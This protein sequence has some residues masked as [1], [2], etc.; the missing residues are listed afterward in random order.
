[1]QSSD[2]GL[3]GH[4]NN[5]SSMESC[6]HGSLIVN[7]VQSPAS[8]SA[9]DES[10]VSIKLSYT[11]EP[12]QPRRTVS[13]EGSGPLRHPTP[14]LQSLQGAYIG[15]VERLEQ[16]AERLSLSS[17]IGE[18]L[19]KM[20]LEQRKSS[21]R[22]SSIMAAQAGQAGGILPSLRQVSTSSNMSNSIR[23]LNN[24]ARSGA[25]PSHGH[26]ISPAGSIRSTS[27]SIHLPRQRQKVLS[28]RVTRIS[29]LDQGE[30]PSRTTNFTSFDKNVNIDQQSIL[31]TE[32]EITQHPTAL[33]NSERLLQP[34][35]LQHDV[36]QTEADYSERPVTAV[37]T[38]DHQHA[39]HLFADFDGVHIPT[40]HNT[41][42]GTDELVKE[43]EN[44]SNFSVREP[45]PINDCSTAPEPISRAQDK[46]YYPAPVPVILNLPP[47]LSKG[48][49]ALQRDTRQSEVIDTASISG[50]RKSVLAPTDLLLSQDESY[51]VSIK[52]H[53][54]RRGMANLPPQLKA[55]LFFEHK[56]VQQSIE[57]KNGSAVATLDSILN[58]SAHAPVNAFIDHPIAGE[59]GA[60]IFGS[61]SVGKGNNGARPMDARPRES[62]SL[63]NI[64]KH[65]SS[66]ATLLEDEK[67]SSLYGTDGILASGNPSAS[68]TAGR[69]T[70][71]DAEG[72][73]L[74]GN[75]EETGNTED[76]FEY[77]A[78]S[79]P[80]AG[81]PTTLLAE[82]QLRKQRQQ[83]RGRTAAKAFPN[84]MHSTL[85]E[86]DAVAQVQKQTRKQKQVTLAW[87]DS[88]AENYRAKNENDEDIPLG[89]LYPSRRILQSR[90]SGYL[91]EDQ[92]LGL[93]AKRAMDDNEPL[94]RRRARLKG[95][96]E[97]A[98]DTGSGTFQSMYPL[99]ERGMTDSNIGRSGE[100]RGECLAQ[101][102]KRLKDIEQR[103]PTRPLTGGF[104]SEVL[105][106]VGI[107]LKATKSTEVVA[108]RTPNPDETLGE[109]R[110]RLQ[111]EKKALLPNV[112]GES[113]D[114]PRLPVTKRHPV[115][116]GLQANRPDALRT[117][118]S[119]S[120]SSR[121]VFAGIASGSQYQSPSVHSPSPGMV[122]EPLSDTIPTGYGFALPGL[123]P[124]GPHMGTVAHPFGA[125]PTTHVN[126]MAFAANAMNLPNS[127]DLS[128][129]SQARISGTGHEQ[130]VVDL[131]QRA[132]IDRWRQSVV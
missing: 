97:I 122:H 65:R 58:A 81:V 100:E 77:P 86:L 1:M 44:A 21:S 85:L 50:D 94:S 108:S 25:V 20:K 31:T 12:E 115:A 3:P 123:A 92:P 82:L 126:P 29:D 121:P 87:E 30:H 124:N 132:L 49:R 41:T 113:I 90:H 45:L 34:I 110:K 119:E 118:S 99:Q 53:E 23:G 57:L 93:A 19:R 66:S 125:A 17:D 13:R 42:T 63:L 80:Y 109:R 35:E 120:I 74:D 102:I 105:S 14:D 7:A 40:R 51:S 26:V 39:M 72:S 103:S 69:V 128:S 46:I 98:R 52:N 11:F 15:N 96:S 5:G 114:N 54:T 106:S 18:E 56:P 10:P 78:E 84:G 111:A 27:Q 37:S 64:L 73:E 61:S 22:S 68:H 112:N 32:H 101:R 8:Y 127:I 2:T 47:K 70:T 28:E 43:V 71:N 79:E 95:D 104:M 9:S 91:E 67:G 60:E 131:K 48:H 83:Q 36:P 59:V 4:L 116:H 75:E 117:T 129:K 33:Q 6:G 38:E 62:R 76:I 24:I 55:E 130:A 16:S 89:V 107:Q 88:N